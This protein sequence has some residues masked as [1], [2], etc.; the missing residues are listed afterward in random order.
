MPVIERSC[1][2][3]LSAYGL[4]TQTAPSCDI[5]CIPYPTYEGNTCG[6]SHLGNTAIQPIRA[7]AIAACFTSTS[8][9]SE[10]EAPTAT[11]CI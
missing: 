3:S 9:S 11:A 6:P 8:S 10:T 1:V 2:S 7:R 5:R 4:K